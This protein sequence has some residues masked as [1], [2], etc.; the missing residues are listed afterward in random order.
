MGLDGQYRD[1]V[2]SPLDEEAGRP[3]PVAEIPSAAAPGRPHSVAIIGAGPAG[4]FAAERLAERGVAVDVY[5]QMPS[6]ARKLLMAGRGGL[7]LTH[8]EPIDAFLARYTP[9]HRLIEG[10]IRAFPPDALRAFA[11]SLG[12][13]TFVGSSGRVFPKAMKASPLLRAWLRRLAGLG[14]A[15]HVRH[16]LVGFGAVTHAPVI[17][18]PDGSTVSKRFDAVVLACGGASWPR[19][20]ADGAWVAML[21][22]L[23]IDVT[24][25][26][27]ANCGVRV[28]WS[29]TTKSRFAGSPL[30][31]V[32]ISVGGQRFP[33]ELVLTAT[34]LE[35][36]PVYAAGPLIRAALATSADGAIQIEIDLRPDM[37]IEALA[38]RLSRPR[39]KQSVSNWLRKAAGLSPPAIAV[40]RDAVRGNLPS[41]ARGLAELI[42]AAPLSVTGQAGLDRAISTAGGLALDGLDDNFML[43]GAPGVFAAGEML[44]WEAPT[45]GYLLQATFA[46][47][48]M[49]ADGAARWLTAFPATAGAPT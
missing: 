45:G 4:L 11:S 9:H 3:A 46:T 24:P 15:L 33:G 2:S 34:G 38:G 43:R 23:G 36:G 1:M 20:G 49:A 25:L 44:D 22:R 6:P 41:D 29:E 37:T 8:S 16:R 18:A 5:D 21:E 48:A 27:A 42:K 39:G 35:G 7:N 28:D 26:V 30:K 47:A 17:L 40:T 19:L 10:A 31:R 13:E 12:E 32:A 14:V